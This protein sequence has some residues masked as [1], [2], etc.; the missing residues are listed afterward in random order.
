M[1]K[2]K[3]KTKKMKTTS[4]I[5]MK[6]S[7]A[8]TK[9]LTTYPILAMPP[10]RPSENP[11]TRNPRTLRPIDLQSTHHCLAKPP[12][13]VSETTPCE[14]N[15]TFFSYKTLLPSYERCLT[16]PPIRIWKNNSGETAM[17]RKWDTCLA[18]HLCA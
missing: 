5:S 3:T 7:M 13:F 4:R 15:E 18:H 2:M 8:A 17:R 16:Q 12:R 11:M 9:P 10:I 14:T 6:K 1:K